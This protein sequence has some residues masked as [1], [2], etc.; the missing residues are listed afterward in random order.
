M[1]D[2]TK[3]LLA[4]AEVTKHYD[5]GAGKVAVLARVNLTVAA[6]ESL[7]IVGPSG[8][9]KSTL[10]NIIGTLDRAS[11]G[12]VELDG[13]EL[14]GLDEVALAGVR[15]REIGFVFQS[16]HL[17]PQC[18]VLENVLVPTLPLTDAELKESAPRAPG[19]SSRKWG[20]AV[21]W[22]IGPDNCPGANASGWRWCGRSSIGRSYCSRMNRP[23]RWTGPRR[24]PGRPAGAPECRGRG[25][26][27]RGDACPRSGED[28]CS[29]C[30]N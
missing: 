16:H 12:R 24:E 1:A 10:L 15:N 20:W 13:R 14:T 5:S 22:G 17:L 2:M 19:N 4:L 3:P 9:G 21:G 6:G 7:A 27:D 25:E 23:A 29:G 30:S 28:D 26:P 11:G 8:C 18:T